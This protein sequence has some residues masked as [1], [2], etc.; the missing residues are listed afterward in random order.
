M[1]VLAAP[2][3]CQLYFPCCVFQTTYYGAI[4]IGTPPQSF[5]VLFDTGSANLWVDSVLCNT[6]ACSEYSWIAS[7]QYYNYV[8]QLTTTSSTGNVTNW[9]T[10]FTTVLLQLSDIFKSNITSTHFPDKYIVDSIFP[11]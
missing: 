3:F 2:L 10:T 5:Q 7:W 6:Q 8:Y 4:T 11:L 9:T 1:N